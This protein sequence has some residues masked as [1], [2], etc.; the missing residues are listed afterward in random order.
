MVSFTIIILKSAGSR[1]SVN[2]TVVIRMMGLDI[3]SFD[4]S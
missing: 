1:E 2:A 4:D 3:T